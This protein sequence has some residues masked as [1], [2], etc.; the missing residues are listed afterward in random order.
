[1]LATLLRLQMV[2]RGRVVGRKQLI[3]V[4]SPMATGRVPG[5]CRC[6]GHRRPRGNVTLVGEAVISQLEQVNPETVGNK[7]HHC[8]DLSIL[9]NAQQFAELSTSLV[10]TEKHK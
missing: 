4:F 3:A 9:A 8:C 2:K 7:G 5:F 1:M 10:R 6:F